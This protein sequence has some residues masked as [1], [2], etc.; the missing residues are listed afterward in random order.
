MGF[1][2]S[3]ILTN[4]PPR[5]LVVPLGFKLGVETDALPYDEWFV[6]SLKSNNQ[7]VFW[8][9]TA[10]FV[11]DITNELMTLSHD[12][13][14]IACQIDEDGESASATCFS[15]GRVKWRIEAGPDADSVVATGRLPSSFERAA[16]D[17]IDKPLSIP[18]ETAAIVSGFN[19][20][21]DLK[22]SAF[23]RLFRITAATDGEL[24]SPSSAKRGLLGKIFGR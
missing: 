1:R 23:N 20:E 22:S 6:G 24:S 11:T 9:E 13:D 12:S 14:V 21:T 10:D 7:T 3:Y 18:T 2:I 16:Q 5:D 15:D 17:F 8:S 4:T 19:P